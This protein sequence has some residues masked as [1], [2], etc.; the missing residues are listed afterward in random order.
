MRQSM[1][2]IRPRLAASLVALATI[3]FIALPAAAD[4]PEGRGAVVLTTSI[5]GL[6]ITQWLVNDTVRTFSLEV[7]DVFQF[8]LRNFP[9]GNLSSVETRVVSG[10]SEQVSV[11]SFAPDGSFQREINQVRQEGA[12][13]SETMTVFDGAGFPQVRRTR[14]LT[15]VGGVQVWNVTIETFSDGQPVLRQELQ[16]PFHHDFVGRPLL[17]RPIAPRGLLSLNSGTSGSQIAPRGG[18]VPFRSTSKD[19]KG[20]TVLTEYLTVDGQLLKTKTK[21]FA[22]RR[23]L[24]QRTEEIYI[25][26]GARVHQTWTR[27]GE[28]TALL[29][30]GP[31]GARS[32][33]PAWEVPG[34]EVALQAGGVVM[35]R[36]VRAEQKFMVGGDGQV[37]ALGTDSAGELGNAESETR[38]ASNSR[39]RGKSDEPRDK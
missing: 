35:G 37:A 36:M 7:A 5:G 14:K 12:V 13:I 21:V 19:A 25:P 26:A 33:G 24:L 2:R 27:A 38:G 17:N 30:R 4:Q 22:P 32:L 6:T 1:R 3:V 11:Q 23:G 20:N 29:S 9:N 31:E 34:F 18:A 15:T 39:G 10:T 16:V 28:E 8:T